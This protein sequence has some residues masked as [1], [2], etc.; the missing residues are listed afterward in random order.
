[1]FK[2]VSSVK[3]VIPIMD[4]KVTRREELRTLNFSFESLGE[5]SCALINEAING[6]KDFLFTIG[7]DRETCR[8]YYPHI[9]FKEKYQKT[10]SNIWYFSLL[11]RRTG[12]IN[13]EVFIKNEYSSVSIT[14]SLTVSNFECR[15]PEIEILNR[16]SQF[17]QPSI[18]LR[19]KRFSI[20]GNT[21]INCKLSIRNIRQWTLF[22]IR[23]SNGDPI[24]QIDI[25]SNPTSTFNELVVPSNSLIYG[26]YRF[27]YKVE[28]YSNNVDL[29]AFQEEVDHYV[30]IVPSGI[31]VQVF[32][33]GMYKIRRGINQNIVLDPTF[34]SYDLDSVYPIKNL[35]FK[36]YCSIFENGIL[37]KSPK[38]SLDNSIDLV[39]IK[40]NFSI[41]SNYS[42]FDRADSFFFESNDNILKIPPRGLA[43]IPFR[44]YMFT[45]MTNYLHNNYLQNVVI[46]IE[47]Y[48]SIPLINIR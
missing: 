43:F 24:R 2:L 18:I 36:Y 25:A 47:S 28:M 35:K 15:R 12:L 37:V 40:K 29:S 21:K 38:I 39:K 26:L 34:Y 48:S 44:Q 45:I 10:Q 30:K 23:E 14:K 5:P 13:I 8:A 6:F 17:F 11:L 42:C 16:S 19:S 4:N 32:P 3:D 33:G 22:F 7:T 31:V 20:I 41:Y 46:E 27:V 1:M 9:E